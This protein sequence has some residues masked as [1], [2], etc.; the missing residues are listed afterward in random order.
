MTPKPW[1]Q[2]KTILLNAIILVVMV[3]APEALPASGEAQVEAVAAANII[4]RYVTGGVQ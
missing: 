2:S 3:L 1:Y 4:M